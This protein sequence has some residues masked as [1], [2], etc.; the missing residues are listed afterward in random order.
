MAE[1]SSFRNALTSSEISRDLREQCKSACAVLTFDSRAILTNGSYLY[2]KIYSL[3]FDEIVFIDI[4]TYIH[5]YIHIRFL[6]RTYFVER[7]TQLI[8]EHQL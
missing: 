1:R 6:S 4:H 2:L 7:S 8:E 5:T 3:K